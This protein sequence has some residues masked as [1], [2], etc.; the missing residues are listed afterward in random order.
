MLP[1]IR[2]EGKICFSK[3]NDTIIKQWR[4]ENN[5]LII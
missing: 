3:V 1:V 5:Y 4:Q 2:W